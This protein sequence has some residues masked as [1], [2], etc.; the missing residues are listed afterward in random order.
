MDAAYPDRAYKDV[1]RDQDG[2]VSEDEWQEG[3]TTDF[4]TFDMDKNGTLSQDE[5]Q[6][7][8]TKG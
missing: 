6:G 8:T 7:G 1:D 4:D 5:L 3:Y 2:M